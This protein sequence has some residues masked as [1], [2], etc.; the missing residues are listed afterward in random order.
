M[1]SLTLLAFILAGVLAFVPSTPDALFHF[2]AKMNASPT[3]VLVPGAFHLRS[4]MD[5][6][7][8]QLK[9]KGYNS[10]SFG[11]PTVN[12]PKFTVTNDAVNL[13]VEVLYPLIEQQGKDVV[14]YL[15]SYAGFPGSAAIKGYSKAERLATGK[16]GGIIGLIYQSAF[17]PLPGDT[18]LKMI[19]GQYAPWQNPDVNT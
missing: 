14:L 13:E 8:L 17:I 3:F 19:G 2:R 7:A 9:N 18:L 10:Q 5:I 1:Y 15:H 4:A 6:L 12:H 16:R 11:L